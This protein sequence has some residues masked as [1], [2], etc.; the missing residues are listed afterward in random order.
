MVMQYI[1]VGLGGAMGAM[2]RLAVGQVV[3]FPFGTLVVNVLG[4]CV[5]GGLWGLGLHDKT[6]P[7][8]GFVML[9]A[10]G[11]FTTFSSFSLDALRLAQSGQIGMACL[12]VMLSFGLTLGGCAL[13][14]IIMGRLA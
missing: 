6:S 13:G 14:Y 5:I 7:V 3:A 1:W 9:G 4:S 11:G 10:L 8:Y 12:Y 2:L